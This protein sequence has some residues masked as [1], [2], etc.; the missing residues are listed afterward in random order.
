MLASPVS[1]LPEGRALPG[2]CWYE[3]KFDGYRALVIVDGGL[4]GGVD[5][6]VDRGVARVQSRRGADLS[7]AFP[8]IAAAAAASAQLPAG[9]VLDGELLIWA[10]N[11]R[12]CCTNW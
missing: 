12:D 2:G 11:S 3:P 1:A 9:T 5:G 7:S 4:D 8:E 10:G 6:G